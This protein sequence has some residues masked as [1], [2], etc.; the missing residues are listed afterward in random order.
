MTQS[1]RALLA[2]L[3]DYAGLFPPAG[4]PLADAAM[5]Y[6]SYRKSER[7]WMLGRFV[8]P[9]ARLNEVAGTEMTVAA[10]GRGGPGRDFVDGLFSDFALIEEAREASGGRL[11]VDVLETKLPPEYVASP[12][13]IRPFLTAP[14]EMAEREGVKLFLEVPAGAERVVEALAGIGSGPDTPGVKLRA[15][16]DAVPTAEHVAAALWGCS[17]EGL[18]FKATAGLHHPLRRANEHGFLNVFVAGVLIAAGSLTPK[19]TVELLGERSPENFDF[20]DDGLSWRGRPATLA[21]VVEARRLFVRSFGSC[22]F[23][24]PNDD[25]RALG[26]M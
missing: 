5:N 10:L 15:G 23:D 2:G 24:E 13:A 9:A 21:Q 1:L 7:A 20:R 16:G 17:A 11:T 3:I 4:L 25:L 6:L 22:S 19:E 14:C 8:L 12:G 18:E 26:L